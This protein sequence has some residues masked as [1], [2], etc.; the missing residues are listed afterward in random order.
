[1][2]NSGLHAKV[3]PN[4]STGLILLETYED[5]EFNALKLYNASGWEVPF[6]M[7]KTES[8]RYTLDLSA[9]PKGLYILSTQ[10]FSEKII[11]E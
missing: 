9:L 3:F 6:S 4:P 2:D 8:N 1:M 5:L 7:N 11:L 10:N